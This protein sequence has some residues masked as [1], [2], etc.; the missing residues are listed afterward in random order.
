M[1]SNLGK[2]NLGLKTPVQDVITLSTEIVKNNVHNGIALLINQCT[3]EL[4]ISFDDL[5]YFSVDEQHNIC[6]NIITILKF[7]K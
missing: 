7:I 1:V 5:G 3:N 6:A 2:I 4:I